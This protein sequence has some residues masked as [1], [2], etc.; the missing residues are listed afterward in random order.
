[1][2]SDLRSIVKARQLD[3]VTMRNIRQNLFFTFIYNTLGVPVPAGLL[4]LVFGF[5]IISDDRRRDHE[6]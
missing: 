5:V 3:R 2:K 4:C 6:F 1:V